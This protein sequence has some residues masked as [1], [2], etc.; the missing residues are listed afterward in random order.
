MALGIWGVGAIFSY[1]PAKIPAKREKPP[2]NREL[3]VVVGVAI[4]LT[5]PSL[6]IKSQ[7]VGKN[8]RAKTVVREKKCVRFSA[9][10][11][12]FLFVFSRMFDLA[13]DVGFR[14]SCYCWKACATL[15]LKISDLRETRLGLERYGPANRGHQIVFGLSKS[16]FPIEIPARS[17]KI[18]MIREFHV[19][20]EHV[21]FPTHP[22]SQIKSL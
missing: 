7:R 12:Y 11:S 3:H 4:F 13:P 2:A 20:S 8:P 15:F 6:R 19:V 17:G 1:F 16:I 22:G 21:F 5:H 9:C 18:L 10:F 14:R